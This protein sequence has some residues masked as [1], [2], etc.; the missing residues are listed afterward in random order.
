MSSWTEEICAE[1]EVFVVAALGRS[2]RE[3][4]ALLA[5]HGRSMVEV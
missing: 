2:S 3:E 1:A 4:H 5:L